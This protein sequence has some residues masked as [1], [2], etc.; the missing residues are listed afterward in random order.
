MHI[1]NLP[2]CQS[3]IHVIYDIY[4]IYNIWHLTYMYMSIWVSKKCYDLRNAVNHLR[5]PKNIVL[6]A[7]N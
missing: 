6:R 2:L 3:T 4:E 5:Y 7:K 1:V